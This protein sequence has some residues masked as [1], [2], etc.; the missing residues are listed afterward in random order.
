MG[1][2]V[3]CIAAREGY[4][5]MVEYLINEAVTLA[6]AGRGRPPFP[7]FA[8]VVK[9]CNYSHKN[10]AGNTPLHLA[11]THPGSRKAERTGPLWPKRPE[12]RT[13]YEKPQIGEVSLQ[14]TVCVKAN[15]PPH[16]PRP[17]CGV[18][19]DGMQAGQLEIVARLVAAGADVNATNCRVSVCCT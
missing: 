7:A 8:P 2:T 9:R 16:P 13:K 14:P 11:L 6:R 18:V 10:N 3:L 5:D 15:P 17:Q 1:N 4:L 19:Y 12:Q